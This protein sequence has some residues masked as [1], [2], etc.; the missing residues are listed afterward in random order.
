MDNIFQKIIVACCFLLVIFL[1]WVIDPLTALKWVKADQY[2]QSGVKGVYTNGD[3]SVPRT[4]A[5][6]IAFLRKFFWR[7]TMVFTVGLEEAHRGYRVG[8]IPGL[9]TKRVFKDLL[10]HTQFRMLVGREGVIFFAINEKGEEVIL[11][12][13]RC[14]IDNVDDRHLPLL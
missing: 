8:Y 12:S 3:S 5:L 7:T 9:G 14:N 2:L 11:K 4:T 13:T 6:N 10:Y 1:I